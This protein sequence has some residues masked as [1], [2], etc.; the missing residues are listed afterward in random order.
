MRPRSLRPLA[1]LL[2]LVCSGCGGGGSGGG[3]GDGGSGAPAN[4]PGGADA[5]AWGDS[6]TSG[7]GAGPGQSFPSQLAGLT[8]LQVFN[9]GVSGQTSP[10]IAARQGGE[11]ALLTLPDDA[12]PRSGH[13]LI[14]DQSDFPITSDG[15]GPLTGTLMGVHGTL[16]FSNGNLVF[17]SDDEGDRVTVPADSPFSPDIADSQSLINVFWIGGNNSNQPATVLSDLAACVAFL[18]SDQFVVLSLLNPST[19]PAG[20]NLYT[21]IISLNDALAA[22]YPDNYLDVRTAL[23]DAFDP[24]IPQDVVDHAADVPPSSL[25]GDDQH[26]NAGGYAVVAAEV[27][28]FLAAKGWL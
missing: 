23:V 28:S 8:T 6:W 3:G 9:A 14:E 17:D 21:E 15:P 12:I 25:R 16:R 2:V 20:S 22:S 7:V 26:P 19:A 13:V 4:Y 11:P 27:A 1:A 10:Q 24:M 5:I 18:S